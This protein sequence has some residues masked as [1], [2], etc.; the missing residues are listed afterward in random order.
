MVL[1]LC[2]DKYYPAPFFKE[3]IKEK[4]ESICDDQFHFSSNI[5]I[6]VK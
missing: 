1:R 5:G 2:F 6:D 3:V 4:V